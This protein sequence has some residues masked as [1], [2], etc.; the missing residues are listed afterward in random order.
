MNVFRYSDVAF[1]TG[2]S[3]GLSYFSPQR[4]VDDALAWMVNAVINVIAHN[5]RKKVYL[6]IVSAS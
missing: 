2:V 6:L 3:P 1:P 4:I 5:I